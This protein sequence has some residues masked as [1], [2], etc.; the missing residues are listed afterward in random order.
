[1]PSRTHRFTRAL[2]FA[3]LVANLSAPRV[4]MAQVSASVRAEA[5]EHFDRG[6]RLFNQQDN[7]GALAEFQRAYE[8]V[9]HPMVLYNLGL[10][11]SAAGR[12][13]QAVEAFDKLIANPTGLDAGRLARA[14]DERARQAALIAEV[15]VTSSV[16]GATVEVDGFEV[17]KTPLAAPLRMAA[18][19]HVVA[20]AA[21]GYAPMQKQINVVGLAKDTVAFELLPSDTQ[22]A[23]L[24]VKTSLLDGDVFVDERA[25]GKTPLAASLALPAG[26]HVIELRRPGYVTAKQSVSLGPG[27]AGE[28]ALEPIVDGAALDH[29][30]GYLVL[31]V[32]E[33]EST[34]FV[35]GQPRGIYTKP[36]H[37]PRGVH[38]LRVE[39]T[40]FFPFERKVDV[41]QASSTN[42]SVDMVPTPE[43]RSA[44]RARTVSQ[45]TWGYIATGVG[46]ALTI[47]G[48][49]F[50]I[51]NKQQHDD[52]EAEFQKQ[53]ARANP[54]GDCY[55]GGI[56]APDCETAQALAL[57][58]LDKVTSQQKYGW[59]AGGVGLATLGVGI[60]VL[61][62]ND[63]PNR[64]EPKPESDVFGKLD[65]LPVYLPGGGGAVLTGS[66]R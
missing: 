5:R 22:P 14:K 60:V 4:A 46:A 59:I 50:L 28:L 48:G 40:G 44:Y 2:A 66:W 57:A 21:A 9:P 27:S 20:L 13:I 3:C 18:G 29:D 61:L 36:L 7:E 30:G 56:V 52:K 65:L 17:G 42:V 41:P 19:T 39:H 16:E 24:S 1:V 53:L 15:T 12:P 64:Y 31:A 23:H 37:L 6:L 63:D 26:N 38:S 32:S 33:P 51:I 55:S 8:L 25:V 58:D 10:V 45:R 62:T 35:D 43:L 54:G 47:G 49:T 34:T 11:L